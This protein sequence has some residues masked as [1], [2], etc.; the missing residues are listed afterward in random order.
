MHANEEMFVCRYGFITTLVGKSTF[1]EF[2]LGMAYASGSKIHLMIVA[3]S[4]MLGF[5]ARTEG[6]GLGK[7]IKDSGMLLR[8]IHKVEFRGRNLI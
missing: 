7:P 4:G 6:D 3:D 1:W 2:H 8:E 5:S